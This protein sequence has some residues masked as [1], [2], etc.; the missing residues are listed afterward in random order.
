[1]QRLVELAERTF[2]RNPERAKRYIYIARKI[3]TKTKTRFPQEL[4]K[5]FCRTCGNFLKKGKNCT[6]ELENQFIKITCSE[7]KRVMRY[8]K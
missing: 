8:P 2:G 4:R 6:I 7:C 1:M 3:G 5:K